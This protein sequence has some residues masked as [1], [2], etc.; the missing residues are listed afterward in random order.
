MQIIWTDEASDDL[1]E[2]YNH[3]SEESRKMAA[4]VLAEIR[5]QVEKLKNFPSMGPFVRHDITR[6]RLI[7]PNIPYFAVYTVQGSDIRVLRVYH[8]RR[9]WI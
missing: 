3:I 1:D 8:M 5:D 2:V 6:R 7:I 9:N 4:R